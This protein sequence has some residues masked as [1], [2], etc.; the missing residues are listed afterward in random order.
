MKKGQLKIY[1]LALLRHGQ[2]VHKINMRQAFILKL[3]LQQHSG[4]G[5]CKAKIKVNNQKI[6]LL[7]RNLAS[8]TTC[9]VETNKPSPRI[10]ID[11]TLNAQVRYEP[12]SSII[13]EKNNYSEKLLQIK[14]SHNYFLFY[15]S[16]DGVGQHEIQTSTE[17]STV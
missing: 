2:Y 17:M 10:L 8:K 15:L 13:S 11:L 3:L 14:F 6:S 5:N 12:Q 9:T 16:M 7:L 1:G 4:N